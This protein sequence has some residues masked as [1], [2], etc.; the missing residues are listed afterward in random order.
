MGVGDGHQVVIYDGAGIFSAARVWWTFRLMGK[1]DVAVLDG[2]F[3][4]GR[5]RGARS[6]TC[7]R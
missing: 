5:P 4:N 3:P 1:T 2:G 7:P 6:R